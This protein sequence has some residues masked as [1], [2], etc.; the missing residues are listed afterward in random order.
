MHAHDI[1]SHPHYV[2]ED[3]TAKQVWKAMSRL[4][5]VTQMT[6]RER[7]E[8]TPEETVRAEM[9]RLGFNPRAAGRV[10]FQC[11][12]AYLKGSH[13]YTNEIQKDWSVLLWLHERCKILLMEGDRSK[14]WLFK[15]HAGSI[16]RRLA[17]IKRHRK[18]MLKRRPVKFMRN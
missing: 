3:M 12:Q 5:R 13:V 17:A 10:S 18:L 7:W 4:F 16:R 9:R 14:L 2:A 6:R 15:S 11:K 8:T 1:Y